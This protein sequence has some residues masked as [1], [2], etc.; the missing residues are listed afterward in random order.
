MALLP[1]TV[2][3]RLVRCGTSV[4]VWGIVPGATVDLRVNGATVQSRA[5]S[6]SW[7]VFTLA[8]ELSANQRVTAR[9]TL[10]LDATTSDSPAVIV[11]DVQLPP[12]PPRLAPT[13]YRCANCI[14]ADGMAPGATVTLLEGDVEGTRTLATAVAD[15]EGAACFGASDLG[16]GQVFA[17]TTVCAS[18]SASSPPTSVVASPASLPAPNL[19]GPIFGCQ[20]FVDMDGLTPSTTAATRSSNACGCCCSATGPRATSCTA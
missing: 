8:S 15:G 4:V 1:P 6:D 5:I 7:A 3:E 9:Q 13:V 12:P 2:G 17:V 10:S 14:Y 11:G 19:H 20:T 18:T 16:A